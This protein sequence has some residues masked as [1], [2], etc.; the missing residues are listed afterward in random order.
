MQHFVFK[1]CKGSLVSVAE[2][3]QAGFL[4]SSAVCPAR[5]PKRQ[6]AVA[7][8]DNRTITESNGRT[9]TAHPKAPLSD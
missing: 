7:S 3:R 9:P 5:S 2:L 1:Q 4:V 6:P 8:A